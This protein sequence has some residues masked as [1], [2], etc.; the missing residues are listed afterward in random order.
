MLEA[1]S[2]ADEAREV[3]R[4]IKKLVVRENVPLASCAIFTPNPSTYH[5]LLRAAAD[6]FGIPI[7]FTLDE[8]LENSPAITSL[9]NLLSLPLSNFNSRHMLNA[10]RSPYLDFSLDDETVDALA[11][12]LEPLMICVL[13]FLIGIVV[14]A[15]YLPLFELVNVIK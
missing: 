15:L 11:S 1:R 13:G 8:P 12:L 2:P 10:L 14:I 9:I 6:E 7:H 3:L 4:W 5:P